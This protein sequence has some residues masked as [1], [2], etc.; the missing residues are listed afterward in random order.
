MG[1]KQRKLR[2]EPLETRKLFAVVSVPD[3][4]PI[5]VQSGQEIN[6]PFSIDDAAGIRGASIQ[7]RYEPSKLELTSGGLQAGDVWGG[8]AS[9]FPT[10][11]MSMG[12]SLHSCFQPWSSRL[13]KET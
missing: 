10:L 8:K 1:K 12:K 3:L 13:V 9:R 2:I 7:F 11:T 6:V 5:D 4:S